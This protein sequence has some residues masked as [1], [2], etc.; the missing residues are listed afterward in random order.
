MNKILWRLGFNRKRTKPRYYRSGI[1]LD[2]VLE[3]KE[4]VRK[5]HCVLINLDVLH[6]ARVQALCVQKK[7]V[8]QVIV[9]V[10]KEVKIEEHRND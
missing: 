9:D 1:T 6:E 3:N 10:A 8:L 5:P 4:I 2:K 7:G